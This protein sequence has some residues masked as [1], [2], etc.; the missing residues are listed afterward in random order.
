LYIHPTARAAVAAAAASFRLIVATGIVAAAFVLALAFGLA[1]TAATDSF[2]LVV[3]AAGAAAAADLAIA[4]A[5][6]HAALALIACSTVSLSFIPNGLLP[7]V[8]RAQATAAFVL[9]TVTEPDALFCHYRRPNF[10][11]K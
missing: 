9:I 10:G 2:R 5:S 1:G 8:R 4:F 6:I 7:L 11:S 3:P